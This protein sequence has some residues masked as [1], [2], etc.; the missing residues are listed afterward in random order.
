MNKSQRAEICRPP[1]AACARAYAPYS[2]FAVG[3]A[4]L[5]SS[6]EVFSGVNVENACY[7]A[8]ICAERTAV[9]KAVGAGER[10]FSAIA[11]VSQGAAAPCGSCRQVMA[12][13]GRD[14]TVI[15]FE[16]DGGVRRETTLR[17]LLPDGFYPENLK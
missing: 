14:I 13:F 1:G 3:A 9:F 7:P 2:G 16:P 8:G 15:M 10:E 4:L 5:A 12:E 6:G 11:V 17:E